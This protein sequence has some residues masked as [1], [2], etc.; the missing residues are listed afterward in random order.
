MVVYDFANRVTKTRRDHTAT[1]PGGTLKTFTIREEYVYDHAG[2]LRFT[3]HK[4]NNRNWRVTAAPL[5]DELNRL[6][7]KRLHA[8]NYNGTS[9][10]DLSSSF[11][12]LQ[13]LD[14]TYNIRGWLTGINDPGSCAAL[15]SDNN[16]ADLF[17]MSL[18]YESNANGA[19]PQYNGNIAGMIWRTNTGGTCINRQQ[20]RFSYDYNNR[21][22][23]A[24]HF[25]HN[26]SAWTFTNN[27][28]E[29][30]IS[31]DLNGNLKTYTRRGLK[32]NSTYDNIDVLTYTYGDAARPDRLTNMTD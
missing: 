3:R 32:P 6:S 20:Y 22:T 29:S 28:S 5:Y 8:S 19:T 9:N 14:Y 18:D 24:A 2:R 17:S 16:M 13:S 1:P 10:I 15:V 25:T 4:I 21:L 11:E 23:A 12:Y 7:D 31:Y 26:G 27:Y 30:N